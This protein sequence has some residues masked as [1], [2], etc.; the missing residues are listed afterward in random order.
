MLLLLLLS[1]FSHV[2]LYATPQTAAHQAPLSPRFSKKEY[3]SGLPFPSPEGLM[4]AMNFCKYFLEYARRWICRFT[5]FIKS[6]FFL[7]IV[8]L[9]IA[10]ISLF[11]PSVYSLCGTPFIDMLVE[12]TVSHRFPGLCSFS[13]L[14]CCF[15][16]SDQ[17]ISMKL[18]SSILVFNSAY[19]NL[20]LGPPDFF[21]FN[22]R[23]STFQSPNFYLCL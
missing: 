22:F 1:R 8:S 10:S 4:N 9:N 15:C 14:F 7:A 12:L 3:W 21:F 18:F 17:I 13:F 11:L 5:Y 23:D 16:S 20:F 2:Q 19:L 6:D